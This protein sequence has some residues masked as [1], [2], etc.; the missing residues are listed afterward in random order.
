MRRPA[1]RERVTMSIA[2]YDD[3]ARRLMRPVV[4]KGGL[5]KVTATLQAGTS[6]VDG[7]FVLTVSRR[8]LSQIGRWY[9]RAG[10]NK[11]AGGWQAQWPMR[12]LGPYL[13]TS[14]PLLL[15][16]NHQ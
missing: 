14:A 4:A 11:R 15:A 3:E 6:C 1:E 7:R 2:L 12:S 13:P 9:L 5:S 8:T 10:T 16:D